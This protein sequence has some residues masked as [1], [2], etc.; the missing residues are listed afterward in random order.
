VSD[1]FNKRT[2]TVIFS[3][4]SVGSGEDA[5]RMGVGAPDVGDDGLLASSTPNMMTAI[6][7]TIDTAI[8]MGIVMPSA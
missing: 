4:I 7:R 3:R 2:P 8:R 6:A 1:A 5:S